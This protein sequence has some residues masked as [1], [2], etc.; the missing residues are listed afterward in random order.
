MSYTN[1]LSTT[2]SDE[3]GKKYFTT[4]RMTIAKFKR[5]QKLVKYL[6]RSCPI[7]TKDTMIEVENSVKVYDICS[8]DVIKDETG[9]WMWNDRYYVGDTT[10]E[11]LTDDILNNSRKVLKWLRDNDYLG[12]D[13]KGKVKV[14]KED[15]IVEIQI[16]SNGKP[17]LAIHLA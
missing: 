17:F 5:Q 3:F 14:V 8:I 12:D 1:L 4:K 7:A 6:E 11:V 2:I 13:S 16:K 15:N 9:G 10:N